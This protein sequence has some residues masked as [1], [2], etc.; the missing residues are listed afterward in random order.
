MKISYGKNVYDYREIRAVTNTLKKSTQMGKNVSNFEKKIG[1]IFTKKYS[2]MVNSGSS[3]L[4]LALNV[5]N[6]KKG[7]EIITPCLNFGTAI[8]AI[9]ISGYKPVFVDVNIHTLQIDTDLIE[10][11]ISKNTKAMVIPNLIGNIPDWYKI[12]KI[13]K[14]YNLKIIED[15]AQAMGSYY[16]GYH[17]G[18][19]SEVAAFSSHPLKNL[20]GLGDGGFITTNSY[21]IYQKIK[22][23]R[24]HGIKKRDYVTILGV[25][26]R[27]DVLNAE[28]L[29]MRLNKLKKIIQIRK[30][31]INFYKRYLKNEFVSII[32]DQ[33]EQINSNVMFL[34]IVKKNRNNLQKFL[35]KH[36]I[37][38]LIYYGTPLHLHPA[39]K[40]LNYKKGSLP[41]SEDI[42]KKVLALPHHQ[43]LNE[44]Q[45]KYV[46]NKINKFFK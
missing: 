6:F 13:A 45:I 38:S 26:S 27:L 42:S 44:N 20:N 24:N 37:Q 3:A 31:N 8:S 43:Y 29:S 39:T 22:L 41:I 11:K 23:F 19:F 17:A 14:K 9:L 7:S 15:A 25:N 5:L 18:S 12:K 2:L 21:K 35:N 34:V 30:R 16:K 10:K 1:N 36:N 40:Y 4:I 33:D 28:I 32:E 46:C